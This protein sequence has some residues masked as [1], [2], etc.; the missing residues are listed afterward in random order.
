MEIFEYIMTLA[1]AAP[2]WV[3]AITVFMV[4]CK[5][6]TALTPTTIDDV[7]YGKIA[8]LWNM[9]SRVVNIIALNILKARNAD[10]T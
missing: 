8:P 1:D 9:I 2:A 10:D 5:G 4:G 7:V 3:T 6:I